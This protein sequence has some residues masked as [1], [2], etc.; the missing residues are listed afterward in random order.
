MIKKL[1][2]SFATLALVC[3]CSNAQKADYT[4]MFSFWTVVSAE[5]GGGPPSDP[6][7]QSDVFID[8][9]IQDADGNAAIDVRWTDP[10]RHRMKIDAS[11][12]PKHMDVSKGTQFGSGETV[13]PGI[14]ELNGDDLKICLD[15]EGK[16]RPTEF[17]TKAGDKCLLLV[18]KRKKL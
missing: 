8:S 7:K 10:P 9:E 12:S 2:L 18:L 3:G 17:K 15:L 6:S 14:Y 11:K 1:T 13:W 16:T 4:S 5:E